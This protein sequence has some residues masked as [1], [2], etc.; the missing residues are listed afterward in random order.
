MALHIVGCD[1]CIGYYHQISPQLPEPATTLEAPAADD[2]S[3]CGAE[4]F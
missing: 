4:A 1:P 3:T 2:A